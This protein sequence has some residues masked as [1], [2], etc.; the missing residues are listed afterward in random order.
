MKTFA[1]APLNR[2]LVK[3]S[4]SRA[5]YL[6]KRG[7]FSFGL[8]LIKAMVSTFLVR[9]GVMGYCQTADDGVGNA[10][11]VELL[12]D[13]F[14]HFAPHI[15]FPVKGLPSS[16]SVTLVSMPFMPGNSR[17]SQVCCGSAISLTATIVAHLLP[18]ARAKVL[19][20]KDDTYLLTPPVLELN[21]F[22]SKQ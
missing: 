15:P 9:R 6:A 17:S 13:P 5:K 19:P 2:K 11:G 20:C 14:H 16:G 1:F 8:H 7:G 10:F 22:M 4:I 18:S 21:Y 12:K 3:F